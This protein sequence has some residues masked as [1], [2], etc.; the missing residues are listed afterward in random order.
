MS[1]AKMAS[2]LNIRLGGIS[3]EEVDEVAEVKIG[4]KRKVE[5]EGEAKPAKKEP[6]YEMVSVN[7]M[8]TYLKCLFPKKSQAQILEGIK[9]FME[10]SP[11]VPVGRYRDRCALDILAHYPSG[12]RW[13]LEQDWYEKK[14]S[15]AELTEFMK[16][17]QLLEKIVLDA[18]GKKEE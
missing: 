9:N 16:E 18:C 8:V 1:F 17:N 5:G 10:C 13:L 15:E 14:Y 3:E 2:R 6:E 12:L 4:K 11:R 7:F